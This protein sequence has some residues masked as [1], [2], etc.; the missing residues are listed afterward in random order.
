MPTREEWAAAYHRQASSDWKLFVE[1]L[2]RGDVPACHALHFLQMATEKLAKAYR[3]RDTA[4]SEDALLTKHVG[5]QKFLNSFLLSPQMR[6]E[7]AGR[8]A[9]LAAIRKGLAPIALAVERLAPAVA[10][11]GSPGNAEYP[12]ELGE[13]VVAPVDHDF[14]EVLLLRGAHGRAF[15]NVVSRALAE[16]RLAEFG[17][18]A[19]ARQSD[20]GHK[21]Y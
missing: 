20:S 13:S 11:E 7:F 16:F 15:L 2:A 9:Q 4:T 21:P 1:L 8:H 19:S 12:W 5:F 17:L 14:H 3:F 6:D 18:A 10:R